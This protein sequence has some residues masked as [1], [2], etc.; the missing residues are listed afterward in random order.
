MW[1]AEKQP[2]AFSDRKIEYFNVRARVHG[3]SAVQVRP[4]LRDVTALTCLPRTRKERAS[5]VIFVPF[6]REEEG[7]ADARTAG[8]FQNADPSTA[9]ATAP[10]AGREESCRGLRSG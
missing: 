6:L 7:F 5:W 3:V 9:V 2:S 10:H 8:A 1:L 4:T